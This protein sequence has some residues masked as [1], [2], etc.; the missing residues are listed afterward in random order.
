MMMKPM[1]RKPAKSRAV[2]RPANP[3]PKEA[4]PTPASQPSAPSPR[5]SEMQA[6]R[7]KVAELEQELQSQRA[8]KENR[9]P[10]AA[11]SSETTQPTVTGRVP[12]LDRQLTNPSPPGVLRP[13]R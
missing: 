7:E 4:K 2:A 6:L 3:N 9:E 1:R 10:S 13:S 11:E 8:I 12:T 5:T